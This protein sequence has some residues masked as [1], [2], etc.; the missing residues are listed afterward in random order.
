MKVLKYVKEANIKIE[1]QPSQV[2]FRLAVSVYLSLVDL[3]RLKDPNHQKKSCM[4]PF[5]SSS[6][7]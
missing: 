3:L 1:D 5:R 6:L 2:E 7:S 4:I